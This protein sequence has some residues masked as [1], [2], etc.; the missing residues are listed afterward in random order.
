MALQEPITV[1]IDVHEEYESD[2]EEI[3][4]NGILHHPMSM[5]IDN[6]PAVHKDQYSNPL[7]R[8]LVPQ[9]DGSRVY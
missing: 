1:L 4:L 3:P 2:A 8:K 7:H 6:F 5:I 9:S